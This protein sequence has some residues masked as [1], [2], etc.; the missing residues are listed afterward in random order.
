[1]NKLLASSLLLAAGVTMNAHA[2]YIS[3]TH[4][5]SN[6]N[7]VALQGLE[8]MPLTYTAGLSRADIEDGFTDRFGTTWAAGEWT[9]ATRKQTAT[10]FGTLWDQRYIGYSNGNYA[11]AS[12]FL[13][14][15]GGLSYD[16]GYG[17]S[18]VDLDGNDPGHYE[19][20][21]YSQII[22]GAERECNADQ[23]L[24]CYG[25][26][27]S[28]D[29]SAYSDYAWDVITNKIVE[30]YN[31]NTGGTGRIGDYVLPN[32]TRAASKTSTLPYNG[33]LLVRTHNVSSPAPVSAPTS[34]SVLAIGLLGLLSL[35][36]RSSHQ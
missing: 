25:F 4:T 8:W 18:R 2:G 21:D 24:T 26:V 22:F 34:L 1:M 19:G 23:S 5:L 35:R 12:W 6:G 17:A 30:S 16:V 27:G 20:Y 28:Y 31:P 33:H 32:Y 10:L 15:F 36:R 13:N 7:T 14:T 29:N 3:G 11:G 9:Y